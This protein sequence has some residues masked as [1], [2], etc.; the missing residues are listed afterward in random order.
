MPAASV[1][2]A[3]KKSPQTGSTIKHLARF[4]PATH[5]MGEPQTRQTDDSRRPTRLTLLRSG[6]GM[7]DPKRW[8]TTAPA[9]LQL[10]LVASSALIVS[11]V[12]GLV[13][14]DTLSDADDIGLTAGAVV[15]V[16]LG[17][18]AAVRLARPG[19][20]RPVAY[21]AP[22]ALV[23]IGAVFAARSYADVCVAA[24]SLLHP[25]QEGADAVI[26]LGPRGDDVR[27][28][29]EIRDGAAA[30]LEAL[31]DAHPEARRIHLTSEGG[32]AAEGA[33]LGD[34]IAA[35]GLTTYVPDYCVSACTLAFVA[36]HERL[37][38][39][40]ARL[41]FHAPFEE[42]LFGQVF[43]G[44]ASD[45]R[46]AYVAHGLDADFVDEALDVGS[47]GMWYPEPDRLL[48]AH[49]VT[50]FVDRDRLPDSN[51]DFD[52]TPQGARATVLR[53]FP[54]LAGLDASAPAL[55]E[56][57]AGW[58]LEAY[59]HDFSEGRVV[60][61][62]HALSDSAVALA[63]AGAG[64][65]ALVDL[66]RFVASAL[67][68]AD[69]QDCV[70]IGAHGDLVTAADLL[71]RD[72]PAAVTTVADLVGAAMSGPRAAAAPATHGRATP[73]VYRDAG[74][75]SCAALRHAFAAALARPR[76]EAAALLR[77]RFTRWAHR[78]VVEL[79]AAISEPR[80]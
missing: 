9:A 77:P 25:A 45:V 61:G 38:L 14:A 26:A 28:S 6:V 39:R 17:F 72:D 76:S 1:A 69:P 49:V 64:D 51:L 2:A 66:A 55:V 44:D 35:H 32:L 11:V 23:L 43:R 20:R 29:G 13:A 53:N 47:D 62:L 80:R 78:S 65:A 52:P 46:A 50:A 74:P 40:D 54:I 30:R 79:A 19:A 34:V 16:A 10:A 31:L 22:L 68:R 4:M 58:Y 5:A 33:A 59:R 70:A 75:E 3:R 42:G 41:G 15:A 63:S 48:A 60:A 73:I 12:R 67:Q 27:L 36:G 71:A 18:V 56:R 8:R 7:D 37:A 21:A 24:E 57:I